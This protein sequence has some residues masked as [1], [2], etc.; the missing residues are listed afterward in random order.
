MSW[1]R[2]GLTSWPSIQEAW[3]M[4]IDACWIIARG[5]RAQLSSARGALFWTVMS[6]MSTQKRQQLA[7]HLSYEV[8][9]RLQELNATQLN[10]V[11][12]SDNPYRWN[13]VHTRR[14]VR[15]GDIDFWKLRVSAPHESPGPWMIGTRDRIGHQV[16]IWGFWT[17]LRANLSQVVPILY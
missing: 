10:I 1:S 11:V 2:F 4:L 9:F 3:R 16:H 15:D 17:S 12:F 13:L 7:Q 6:I 8:I 5:T 14:W